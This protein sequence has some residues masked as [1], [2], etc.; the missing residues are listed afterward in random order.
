[1][2]PVAELPREH[3]PPAETA[4]APAFDEDDERFFLAEDSLAPTEIAVSALPEDEELEEGQ[5]DARVMHVDSPRRRTFA[6][7]V[8]AIVILAS[9]VCV[10]AFAGH[11]QRPVAPAAAPVAA[12][13][14]ALVVATP[15]PVAP[16]VFTGE[17]PPLPVPRTVDPKAARDARELARGALARG[18]VARA[19]STG[20]ESVELDP[21][22]AEAWLVLGAAEMAYGKRRDAR[23][24][25]TACTKIA[26]R[27]PRHECA[28]MLQ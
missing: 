6:R 12:R 27:G 8:G 26:T 9:G 22:D 7:Y 18:D 4:P 24:T 20:I 16:V 11:A 25:F 13:P 23:S 2:P 17:R 14:A 1:V 5:N 10:A 19:V 3:A 15:E 21:S 28:Q